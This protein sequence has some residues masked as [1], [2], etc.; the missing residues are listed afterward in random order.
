LEIDDE[1]LHTSVLE[2]GDALFDRF[3][4]PD[5]TVGGDVTRVA[6]RGV[7]REVQEP[8]GSRLAR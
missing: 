5:Q 7:R 8:R 2:C 3:D 1:F 4:C 6:E